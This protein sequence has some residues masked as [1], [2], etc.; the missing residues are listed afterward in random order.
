MLQFKTKN[1]DTLQKT[2]NQYFVVKH[3][4]TEILQRLRKESFQTV[5]VK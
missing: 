1:I 2:G 5:I 3:S 4:R